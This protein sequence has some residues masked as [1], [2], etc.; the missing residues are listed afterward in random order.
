MCIAVHVARSLL[1]GCSLLDLRKIVS[2]NI[3]ATKEGNAEF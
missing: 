3:K 2:G 1:T